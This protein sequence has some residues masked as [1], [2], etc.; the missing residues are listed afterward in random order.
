MKKLT[1]FIFFLLAVFLGGCATREDVLILDNRTASLEQQLWIL[2]D[3]MEGMKKTLPRRIE[4]AEKKIDSTLQPVHQNQANTLAQ[5]EELKTQIQALQGRLEAFE[6]SQKKEQNRLSESLVKDLKELQNRVQRLEQPPLPPKPPLQ[7]S[8]SSPEPDI[9]T[10]KDKVIPR[11]PKEDEKESKEPVKEKGK[12]KTTP[13]ELYGEADALLK[14]KAF[15]EAQKKYEDYLKIDPKGKYVEEA[16]FGLAESLFGAKHYEE[17]ILG[18]QKLIKSSP[19][20]KSVPEALY[21]QAV[22]FLGLKDSGSARLLLEK[23]VKNYPKSS[24]AKLA[25]KKLKTL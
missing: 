16:R 6:Y 19:K 18:Y 4:Q 8:S 5:I 2:R 20:S 24:Q 7:K 3:S 11:E 10:D 13:E 21:K 1:R 23:L 9:K 25:Q 15:E 14:K 12:S 22:S 17:A